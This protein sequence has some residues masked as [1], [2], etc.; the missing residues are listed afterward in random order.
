MNKK[1]IT[2]ILILL[3]FISFLPVYS[4]AINSVQKQ[5]HELDK[6]EQNNKDPFFKA[7]FKDEAEIWTSPLKF[8]LKD[9]IT[10]AGLSVFTAY[11]IK[12]DESI[13]TRFKAYQNKNKW[14]DSFSPIITLLG[15]GNVSLGISGLFYLSG[16]IFKDKKAKN[17]SKLVL[18]SLIHSGVVVQLIKH[19]AGRQR[20]EAQNGVDHWEGPAGFFKRY[21]NKR[22]MFYDAFPSG[23]TITV[24]S[25]ATVIAHQYNKSPVV[26]L[27]C[28]GLATLSGLSRITEDKHWFSDVFVGAILGFAIGKF[29]Y[30][31]RSQKFMIMP[32]TKKGTIGFNIGFNI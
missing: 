30:K 11:L 13:Y 2:I 1:K 27:I 19:L 14:V 10:F 18:M 4:D 7:I 26:P 15:D 21:K 20:P 24:W 5:N 9:W 23:H 28:Y 32:I 31:K 22:D 6:G 8:S 12:N 25:T 29:I 16:A 17:T 3:I